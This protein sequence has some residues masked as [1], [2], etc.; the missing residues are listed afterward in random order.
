M[1]FGGAIAGTGE[2]RRPS[3]RCSVPRRRRA[4]ACGPAPRGRQRDRAAAVGEDQQR[5]LR[6]GAGSPPRS[7]RV[8][9][10]RHE[11]RPRRAS[12]RRSASASSRS[13][14]SRTR[15]SRPRGRRSSRRRD[16]P[17]SPS[18]EL[19][20]RVERAKGPRRRAVGTP[21]AAASSFMKAFEP[22]EPG[23]RLPRPGPGDGPPAGAGGRRGHR[24][25]APPGPMTYRSAS[26]SFG[27][28]AE[29]R[30]RRLPS[31]LVLAPEIPGFP[32]VTTTSVTALPAPLRGRARR[33]R[34]DDADGHAAKRTYCSRP[35]PTP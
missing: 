28:A 16:R 11:G 32:G 34:A 33:A 3:R 21:A 14:R 30:E 26:I 13:S 19:L 18:K 22:S 25:E 1:T 7:R 10:R 29:S 6:T 8:A 5:E 15:P 27:G 24:R 35:A 9:R 17:E 2:Y 23:A 20:G 12:R 4:G 31:G